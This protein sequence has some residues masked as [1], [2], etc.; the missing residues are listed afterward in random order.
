MTLH[1]RAPR[2]ALKLSSLSLVL[3]LA[4]GPA[5]GYIIETTVPPTGCPVPNHWPIVGPSSIH[6][7]W[8]ASIAPNTVITA[9][10]YATSQQLTEIG[11]VVQQSLAAWT[12]VSGTIANPST[13]P[14]VVA[15]IAQ[16]ADTNACTNDAESNVDGLNTICFNQASSAFMNDGVLAFTRVITANAAG[17][18]IGSAPPALFT[19][20]ILDSDTLF[21]NTG[22]VTFATPS[23]LNTP[24]GVGAY[25]LESL[26]T[27]ELGHFFGLDHSA[28]RRAILYPFA[29]TPGTFIGQRPSS[30]APDAMLSDDDRTGLRVLYPDPADTVHVGTI[31][32]RILP[33]NPFALAAIP[34]AS[35]DQAVTGMFGTQVVAEDADTGNIIAA[36]MGGWSCTSGQV[37]FDGSYT[38]SRLPVPA[39]YKVYVE[40]L[41]GLATSGDFYETAKGI[42]GASATNNCTEPEANTNFTTRVRPSP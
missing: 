29:P 32:G 14:G 20:Q 15:P 26:L 34:P 7:R 33:A 23:G 36:T 30:G 13:V 35:P 4:L 39:N 37:Q 27:H 31:A 18:T 17:A 10:P 11:A 3:A 24:Q 1:I 19:G 6:L 12:G 2:V 38:I 25:D 9:A 41:D 8:S 16:V 40:P 22:D 21:N 5:H 42:C 28:V